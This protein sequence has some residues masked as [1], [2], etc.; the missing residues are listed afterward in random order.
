MKIGQGRGLEKI[1]EILKIRFGF[2]REA[3]D[4]VRSQGRVRP[5][6]PQLSENAGIFRGRRVPPHP[7]EDI[8]RRVLERKMEMRAHHSITGD[9]PDQFLV[10]R[11]RVERAQAQPA[12]AGDGRQLAQEP[13]ERAGG[14]EVPPV[15]REMDAAENDLPEPAVR[16][17]PRPLE[18]PHP[19]SRLRPLPLT[20]GMTQNVQRW[21]QP[22]WILRSARE[23]R[24]AGA[25]AAP[26]GRPAA[27]LSGRSC[28]SLVRQHHP[29]LGHGR[30]APPGRARP[31]SPR[32]PAWPAG[33]GGRRAG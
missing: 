29:S 23:R 8:L 32:P 19:G 3:D 21:S 16:Q 7:P 27:T 17:V 28:F 24:G 20:L 1:A 11:A 2:A 30:A 6:G 33:S 5:E 15:G 22:S 31:S 26:A 13:G 18:D 25:A 9:E 10:Q 14:L 4:D 12:D